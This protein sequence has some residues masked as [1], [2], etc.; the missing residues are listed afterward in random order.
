[1]K[2]KLIKRMLSNVQSHEIIVKVLKN[3][4]LK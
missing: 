4:K 1:M 3:H 2:T